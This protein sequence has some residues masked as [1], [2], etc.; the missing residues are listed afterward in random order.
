[1]SQRLSVTSVRLDSETLAP[2]SEAK[3]RYLDGLVGA[4]AQVQI[5]ATSH[6]S[7]QLGI[8]FEALL[9]G[10]APTVVFPD[11]VTEDVY[12]PDRLRAVVS[13]GIVAWP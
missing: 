12:S 11:G 3:E 5:F 8:G 2:P 9:K 7:L 4:S 13:L 10:T 6:L 1:M